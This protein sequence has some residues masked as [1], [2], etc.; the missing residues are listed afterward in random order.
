LLLFHFCVKV[1]V[2][3][4]VFQEEDL[5][6]NTLGASGGLR[7]R[8]HLRGETGI[9]VMTVVTIMIMIIRDTREEE[10]IRKHRN[11]G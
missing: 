8:D 9:Q 7:T 3:P 5:A 6:E 1:L 4:E 11:R 10:G 2:D